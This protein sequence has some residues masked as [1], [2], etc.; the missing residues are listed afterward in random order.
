MFIPTV[1]SIYLC[2][3][4][5]AVSQ[6]ITKIV[7]V[8]VLLYIETIL[9]SLRTCMCLLVYFLQSMALFFKALR[10]DAEWATVA[11]SRMAPRGSWCPPML[12]L[13]HSAFIN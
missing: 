2:A 3:S 8:Y 12:F 6:T 10:A 7:Y 9:V 13:V 1:D 4:S 5:P 11:S